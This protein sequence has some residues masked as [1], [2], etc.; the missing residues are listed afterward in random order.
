MFFPL[1]S[2]LL[3]LSAVC[4][5]T[6]YRSHKT[7]LCPEGEWERETQVH[8]MAHHM[9]ACTNSTHAYVFCDEGSLCFDMP[10]LS[11]LLSRIHSHSLTLSISPSISSLGLLAHSLTHS[12]LTL[13]HLRCSN[14]FLLLCSL[15]NIVKIVSIL[16]L[17]TI[18]Q[19]H[20]H[21]SPL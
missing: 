8:P 14:G 10:C 9:H 2:S 3:V 12:P 7:S 5:T 20:M 18:H 6:I 15:I 19:V 16:D 4:S 11:C 21:S 1:T 17:G 13:P